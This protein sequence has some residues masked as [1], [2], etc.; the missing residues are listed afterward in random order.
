MAQP[1]GPPPSIRLRRKPP[2]NLGLPPRSPSSSPADVSTA[3]LEAVPGGWREIGALLILHLPDDCLRRVL[4]CLDVRDL[5]SVTCCSTTLNELARSNAIW[6][7][8]CLRAGIGG[9]MLAAARR[10]ASGRMTP[11]GRMS[12]R[13]SGGLH[14]P[15]WKDL[16]YNACVCDHRQGWR[17]FRWEDGHKE[18]A[19]ER[20]DILRQL[21]GDEPSLSVGCT[22]R[23]C[24]RSFAATFTA[25]KEGE[26][27]IDSFRTFA[28]WFETAVVTTVHFRDRAEA[29]L[30]GRGSVSSWRETWLEEYYWQ[31]A[32]HQTLLTLLLMLL[33]LWW[34][35]ADWEQGGYLEWPPFSSPSRWPAWTWEGVS[36]SAERAQAAA[37]PAYSPCA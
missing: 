21:P 2:A 4:V 17:A 33:F 14:E 1:V 35:P 37:Q 27:G 23:R 28:S 6:R 8:L 36:G 3:E 24:G 31:R 5:L 7:R 22:C 18:R 11:L 16:Y 9:D 20:T 12:S 34:W 32:R 19:A 25:L 10:P 15:D 29:P 30:A 13:L 26:D